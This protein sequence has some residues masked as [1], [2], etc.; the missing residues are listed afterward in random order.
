MHDSNLLHYFQ[1][2]RP[3]VEKKASREDVSVVRL[4]IKMVRHVHKSSAFS[5]ERSPT[6]MFVCLFVCFFLTDCEVSVR[7]S[8]DTIVRLGIIMIR[9]EELDTAIAVVNVQDIDIS[10]LLIAKGS[11]ASDRTA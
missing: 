8:R 5:K 3:L 6:D 2:R 9:P 10:T 7:F 4:E 1:F 11:L